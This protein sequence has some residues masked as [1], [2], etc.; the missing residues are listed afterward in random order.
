GKRFLSPSHQ[1][2]IDRE[3]LILSPHER[4]WDE[5]II[6][7]DQREVILGSLEMEIEKANSLEISKD[8]LIAKLDADKLKFP[9]RW[10]KWKPGDF[11]Y[12][13]GM[14]HKRKLSDF[15]ID[16]KVALTDKDSVTVLESGGEIAWVVGYRIDNRF[17]I[18]PQ[19]RS[20]LSFNINLYFT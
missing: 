3:H 14:D 10:R 13:L 20:A 16:N 4:F 11:F 7:A 9:L 18:T 17:K 15:L 12:P 19:T 1:L 2:V 6:N 8:S 5:V